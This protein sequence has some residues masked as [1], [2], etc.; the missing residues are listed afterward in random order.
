MSKVYTEQELFDEIV[1]VMGE[2]FE[3]DP[4]TV[5]RESRLVEDLDLDSIDAVDMIVHLQ[6]MIGRRIKPEAFKSVRTVGDVID[7]IV[8]MAKEADAK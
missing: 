1:R 2:L 7:V 5:T 8:T 3:I 6:N 4:S